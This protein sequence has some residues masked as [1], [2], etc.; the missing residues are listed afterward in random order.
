MRRTL[1]EP[2]RTAAL[3]T[4]DRGLA[5]R[6]T[7]ELAR[8]GVE[9]DDSA[10]RPLAT[11]PAGTFF[12]LAA[13]AAAEGFPPAELLAL[14]K[15]PLAAGGR[16][17]AAFRHLARR[18][19][20]AALRGPRP[21]AG[22]DGLIKALPKDARDLVGILDALKV[23]AA[24]LMDLLVRRAARFSDVLV[25]H[26]RFIEDLAADDRA[27]GAERLWTGEDGEALAAFVAE[28]DDAGSAFDGLAMEGR[29]YPALLGALLGGRV[30][31]PRYGRHPRLFVWGLLEARL[32]QADVLILGGLN[33]ET[34]PPE[35]KASPW[36]SRPIMADFGLPLPERRIGMTAHDFA[37]AVCAPT[38]F[39]TRARRVN[40]TPSVPSR[41]LLR[42]DA[43]L[44]GT[45]GEARFAP[46][47]K[48]LHW[49]HEV[50]RPDAVRPVT[51]PRPCPPVAARPRMLSVSRIE[52]WVRD[53]YAIYAERVLG[54]RVLDPIDA[55]PGAADRGTIIHEALERF[56]AEHPGTL[57]EDAEERLLETGRRTFADALAWPGV[58]AFWW[59]RFVRIARWFIAYE[60]GR[61]DAGARPLA[62]E[63]VGRLDIA[64]AYAPFTLTARADRIDR[65]SAGALG[66]VDYKTGSLPSWNQVKSGLSP[67]LTLEAAIAAA[68]GFDGVPAEA[69]NELI[70][71]RLSGGRTPGEERV[72]R[73]DIT[74]L[75]EEAM[76]GLRTRIARFDHPE[77]PYLSRPV[78]QFLGRYGDYDHLARVKEWSSGGGDGE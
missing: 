9:V 46:D 24:P 69:V 64:A 7:A 37:Q 53:P 10:G 63:A 42:L 51:P 56:I 54:L 43:Y 73:E 6:V 32:Q 60:R 65:T 2:G 39:L 76:A 74:V 38:V 11:T 44:R 47:T 49:V 67:Q 58:R 71:L 36:M 78:P 68:G 29:D 34:W 33:E 14:L 18:L 22:I 15:H 62:I 25:A 1:E 31:R 3:I 55:D 77:T 5:R 8:F 48:W 59:P 27:S 66:I 28:L 35:A 23:A 17:P 16:S 50:D 4:P 75:A 41:W 45:E 52:T 57:P 20:V 26:V 12:R 13:Q 30:V 21:G 61:R 72:L 70:Y 40:G 19:E